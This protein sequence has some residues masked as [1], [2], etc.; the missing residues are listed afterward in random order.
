MKPKKFPA[1][2]GTLIFHL[3]NAH[4]YLLVLEI[5][6]EF[7]SVYYPNTRVFMKFRKEFFLEQISHNSNRIWIVK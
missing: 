2:V 4:H 6:E 3:S 1:K 7:V 5:S